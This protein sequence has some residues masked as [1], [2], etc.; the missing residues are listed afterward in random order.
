MSL[1]YILPKCVRTREPEDVCC[2]SWCT[3]ISDNTHNPIRLNN[4]KNHTALPY[5][6][7]ILAATTEYI[8]HS[9]FL[10]LCG[11]AIIY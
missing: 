1:P 8:L 3:Y 11:M 5:I 2:V 9:P 6:T 7:L 4:L 10:P